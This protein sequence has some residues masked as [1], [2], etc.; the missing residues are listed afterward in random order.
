MRTMHTTI[1]SVSMCTIHTASDPAVLRLHRLH[2]RCERVELAQHGGRVLAG[3]GAI[4]GQLV[5]H[6][7]ERLVAALGLLHPL[8]ERLVRGSLHLRKLFRAEPRPLAAAQLERVLPDGA[9]QLRQRLPVLCKLSGRLRRQPEAS[10]IRLGCR[11]S[12]GSQAEG[13]PYWA[14][15]H[16]GRALTATGQERRG[17]LLHQLACCC[18]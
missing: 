13:M 3:G 8:L 15:S 18:I 14:C 6:L 7:A 4:R 10:S 1:R 16:T 12:S 2:A 17:H 11:N 9:Q 5:H